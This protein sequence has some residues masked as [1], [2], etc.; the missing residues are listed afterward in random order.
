V[1]STKRFGLIVVDA[2]PGADRGGDQVS[3]PLDVRIPTTRACCRCPLS[4]TGRIL[5]PLS[6]DKAILPDIEDT[7]IQGW[8]VEERLPRVI[9]D[10]DCAATDLPV[11][12]KKKGAGIPITA[13]AR[14][15]SSIRHRQE[16]DPLALGTIE[17]V[18]PE[19]AIRERE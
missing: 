9:S 14:D 8:S 18:S 4:G 15:R 12:E 19:R 16:G 11:I 6:I 1:L 3:L 7:E 5:I 10:L 13:S 2:G 17:S